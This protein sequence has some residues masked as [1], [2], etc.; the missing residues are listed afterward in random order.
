MLLS[1]RDQTRIERQLSRCLTEACETGK[2]QIVGFSWLTHEVDYARFPE[3][4]QV[5]WIFTTEAQ[6]TDALAQ[7]QDVLMQTLTRAALDEAGIDMA[8][9][10]APVRFDSEEACTRHDGGDWQHRLARSAKT[11]H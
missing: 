1:K 2:A 3:S 7:G 10:I 8:K 6:K 4:L 9:L 11:R 5:T